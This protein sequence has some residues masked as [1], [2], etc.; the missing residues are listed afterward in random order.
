MASGSEHV[1][2][3]ENDGPGFRIYNNPTWR[4]E[5]LKPIHT[6]YCRGILFS[7]FPADYQEYDTSK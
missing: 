5:L 2:E 1:L 3:G 4:M 6:K 7:K